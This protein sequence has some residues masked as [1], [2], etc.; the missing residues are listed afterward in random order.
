MA[1]PVQSLLLAHI[2][3][4]RSVPPLLLA[5]IPAPRSVPPLA[6]SAQLSALATK[7]PLD[8]PGRVVLHDQGEY[9]RDLT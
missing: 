6:I 8:N 4:S 2:P 3:A 7:I 9:C 5:H 1:V